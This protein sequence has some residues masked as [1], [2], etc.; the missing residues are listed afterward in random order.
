MGKSRSAVASLR[1]ASACVSAVATDFAI[2][3][4]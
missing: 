2:I 1:I 4:S 3:A